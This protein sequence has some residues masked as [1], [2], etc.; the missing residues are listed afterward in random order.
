MSRITRFEKARL[1]TARALQLS[2]G[3][4]PLVKTESGMSAYD[5][6]KS[7]LAQSVLPLAVIR[8][9]PDGRIEKIAV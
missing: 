3:A 9:Y 2:F 1:V 8:R 6:A 4:P 7:E 5:L